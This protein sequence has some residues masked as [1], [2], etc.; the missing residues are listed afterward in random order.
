MLTASLALDACALLAF[1]ALSLAAPDWLWTLLLTGAD[2][3]Q[4][5]PL[6]SAAVA[7]HLSR[8]FGLFVVL[9]S[10]VCVLAAC[11]S[12]ERF[13]RR[14]VATFVIGLSAF[15][16]LF[17]LWLLVDASLEPW[18]H[19]GVNSALMLI[20]V[21][22]L[23]VDLFHAETRD[24]GRA[25]RAARRKARGEENE[26]AIDSRSIL[27]AM[28]D[29]AEAEAEEAEAA[30]SRAATAGAA[31]SSAKAPSSLASSSSLPSDD[32]APSSTA[33]SSVSVE[34]APDPGWSRLLALAGTQRSMLV[35]GCVALLVRL[36]FSLAV[37]HFVSECLGAVISGDHQQAW[38]SITA[39]AI[40]GTI[41]AILDFFNFYLF[42]LAQQRVVK[43]LRIGLFQNILRQEMGFFDATSVGFLT[44]RLNSDTAEMS[45]N[46]TFVF[47]FSIESV[48][49]IGGI[50]TYMFLREWRLALAAC[51]AIPFIALV[52][53]HYGRWLHDN[54]QQVQSA[55]AEVN[56][57]AQETLSSIRTV[58]SFANEGHE[59]ARFSERIEILF[60]LNVRQL[61]LQSIYYMVIATFLVNCVV[62]AGLL[63]YGSRLV[64]AGQM[65]T[66]ALIAFML[67]Q[68]QLQGCCQNL[69]DTFNSLL[70]STG[71]GTF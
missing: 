55:L 46:L 40:A 5:P 69:F 11:Y 53:R 18:V 58:F 27:L 71:A 16:I 68:G 44:S 38:W 7:V 19:L 24:K 9:F 29:A 34:D 35:A 2:A 10:A 67:Y 41:D 1:G 39:L 57:V 14:V 42:G 21:A 6:L 26:V 51:T 60:R 70:K 49:R 48:V 62:Q 13:L 25:A 45:N 63:A 50:M 52:N 28:H 20:N 64:F 23:I 30:A 17:D 4:H 33:A 36:P 47:R 66:S 61:F 59:V 54:A 65:E 15:S 43:E 22:G 56:S 3:A 12:G 31:A 32:R 8:L 37:P